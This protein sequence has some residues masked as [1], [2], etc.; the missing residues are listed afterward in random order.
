MTMVDYARRSDRAG[1]LLA[2]GLLCFLSLT[3]AVPEVA[4][5]RWG[6][7]GESTTNKSTYDQSLTFDA[8][9]REGLDPRSD[10][11]ILNH[12][13]YYLLGERAKAAGVG[14]EEELY[15]ESLRA[16]HFAADSTSVMTIYDQAFLSLDKSRHAGTGNSNAFIDSVL[17]AARLPQVCT[18][19]GFDQAHGLSDWGKI[20]TRVGPMSDVWL[21]PTVVLG[22][23]TDGVTYRAI[24]DSFGVYS[25]IEAA[26]DGVSMLSCAGS[27]RR[28]PESQK[29]VL[30][31][32]NRLI[33]PVTYD[34]AEV[35]QIQVAKVPCPLSGV[36]LDAGDPF[37]ES[38][39][40]GNRLV[41]DIAAQTDDF[42][43][44]VDGRRLVS[45]D[46]AYRIDGPS[47][48]REMID[49]LHFEYDMTENPGRG[50]VARF[51]S[52]PFPRAQECRFELA[53][54]SGTKTKM[55][56]KVLSDR[57]DDV[58]LTLVRS[59]ETSLTR[60]PG[61]AVG[62][63]KRGDTVDVFFS[64]ENMP[65]H[66]S[67]F[68]CTAIVVLFAPRSADGVVS[69]GD[70]LGFSWID[71]GSRES[72]ITLDR[73]IASW[74]EMYCGRWTISTEQPRGYFTQRVVIPK[75][76][77]IGRN[78]LVAE[79]YRIVSPQSRAVERIAEGQVMVQVE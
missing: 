72:L 78:S 77:A 54:T 8:C 21:S 9:E 75:N 69:F 34:E 10:W 31:S 36:W 64:M 48:E 55:F 27:L 73:A 18:L 4:R 13:M 40:D 53:I 45:L 32:E 29:L 44:K 71:T 19:R 79:F 62:P 6:W 51:V 66:D 3:C 65:P 33:T 68:G 60:V 1:Q 11:R 58:A 25:I 24:E 28:Q 42:A 23:G 61:F 47:V 52:P 38:P 14:S 17:I 41:V 2:I 56:R 67:L 76:A 46:V 49:S 59:P 63:V 26:D 15:L 37:F 5:E 30:T 7:E 20:I 43:R 39:W 12:M 70:S 22:T 16:Y 50:F 57:E 35:R 74:G